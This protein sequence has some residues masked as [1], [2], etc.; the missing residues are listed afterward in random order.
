MEKLALIEF[1]RYPQ[2]ALDS[3]DTPGSAQCSGFA[4]VSLLGIMGGQLRICGPFHFATKY[5]RCYLQRV[6]DRTLGKE[7]YAQRPVDAYLLRRFLLDLVPVLT[8]AAACDGKVHLKHDDDKGDHVLVDS[9]FDITGV[10]DWECAQTA[11]AAEA[12]KSP[13]RLLPVA[14]FYAGKGAIGADEAFQRF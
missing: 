2:P 1:Y 13:V 14:D 4:H 11:A 8:P 3:L 10:I 12:F 7:M 6:L 5:L 9:S